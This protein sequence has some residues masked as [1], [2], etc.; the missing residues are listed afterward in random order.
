MKT[1]C[2]V[3]NYNYA[4]YVV[5]A[6]DSA[7]AQTVPFDEIIVVDD[8]STDDSLDV[9]R[10]KYGKL[11]QVK[12]IAKT[13]AGQLSCFNE[14]FAASSGELIFFLD[15]DDAFEKNYVEQALKVYQRQPS[16]DF[17]YCAHRLFGDRNDVNRAWDADRD[18][19]YSLVLTH[20][21]KIW[22]GAPTSCFSCRRRILKQVLPLPLEDDWR[23]RADDCII[24]GASLA[25]GRK[26]Y[27]SQPLVRY[28]VHGRNGH[29][30][31]QFDNAYKFRRKVA[32]NRLIGHLVRQIGY[33][34]D[35]LSDLIY[36][37]F[38]SLPH[39]PFRS[40]KQYCRIAMRSGISLPRRLRMVSLLC[41]DYIVRP[42]TAK[43]QPAA[44]RPEPATLPIDVEQPR[45]NA[46]PAALEVGARRRA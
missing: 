19:G 44:N 28:R 7:L 23:S 43:N 5:E 2:L 41:A 17:L 39:R 8:G 6:V 42:L 38:R 34:V 32:I 10:R 18:M 13:N 37:E 1:S 31:Q 25:G 36:S 24:F 26:Y 9:L 11:E 33:D 40:L 14:G 35:Q 3:N 46:V 30:G 20:Y 29:F 16:V 21:L 45:V 15:A 22:I 27:L 4:R 12:I